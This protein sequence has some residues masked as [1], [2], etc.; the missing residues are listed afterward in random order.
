RA[1]YEKLLAAN[2]ESTFALNNLAYLYSEQFGMLDKAYDMARKARELLGYKNQPSENLIDST[3]RTTRGLR[4]YQAY[5]A[6]TLGWILFKRGEYP[7]A[8][9]LLQESAQ[10]MSADKMPA[11]AQEYF[12]LGMTY[13][14]LGQE[15]RSRNAFNR[16]LSLNQEFTGKEEAARR[17]ALLAINGKTAGADILASLEKQL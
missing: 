15:E 7:W 5:T 3:V 10:K 13:Y 4:T 12:H 9:S 14:M 8:L 11:E 17:L 16:A 1:T 2:P 6:G